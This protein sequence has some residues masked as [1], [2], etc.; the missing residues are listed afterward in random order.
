[1]PSSSFTA[2]TH[3]RSCQC[4]VSSSVVSHRHSPKPPPHRCTCY[5]AFHDVLRP[6]FRT[7]NLLLTMCL[8][9][10][11]A[12]H[13]SVLAHRSYRPCRQPLQPLLYSRCTIEVAIIRACRNSP[14]PLLILVVMKNR[15]REVS[16]P[17]LK[18]NR[19]RT[20]YVPG[21]VIHVHNDYINDS[22]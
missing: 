7:G 20:M 16:H 5:P 18:V 2:C 12:H 22:S 17:V 21:S 6:S 8:C 19:M 15:H 9:R 13:C 14:T 3:R 4:G 1:V 10:A 11:Y